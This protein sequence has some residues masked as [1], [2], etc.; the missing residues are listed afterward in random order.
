[1]VET[2][3]EGLAPQPV[4]GA[5]LPGW[6]DEI[7]NAAESSIINVNKQKGFLLPHFFVFLI[8]GNI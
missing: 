8:F 5:C 2:H 6:H 4:H 1:M 3:M 7:S